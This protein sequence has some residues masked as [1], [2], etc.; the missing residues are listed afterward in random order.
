MPQTGILSPDGTVNVLVAQ[1]YHQDGRL[2]ETFI[3][4]RQHTRIE[5]EVESVKL[6]N[7]L[8]PKGCPNHVQIMEHEV[9]SKDPIAQIADHGAFVK[10][11]QGVMVAFRNA[12][13]RRFGSSNGPW[14]S[15]LNLQVDPARNELIEASRYI[16]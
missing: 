16:P 9:L 6:Y 11:L 2:A 3:F 5:I 12:I 14:H 15:F 10:E 4:S 1:V 7:V 8:H 13:L